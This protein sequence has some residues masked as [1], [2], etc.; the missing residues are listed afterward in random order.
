MNYF[1]SL[2]TFWN[3]KGT[4]YNYDYP[5]IDSIIFTYRLLTLQ[6]FKMIK[7]TFYKAPKEQ[8]ERS[9]H[10]INGFNLPNTMDF[11]KWGDYEI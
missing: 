4:E 3:V 8:L 6:K 9:N 1:I 10:K 11:R 2:N 7:S 5:Q